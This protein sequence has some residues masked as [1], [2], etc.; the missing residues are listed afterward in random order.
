M[1]ILI[2]HTR[3]QLHGG[4]DSVVE[5]ELKLLKQ[6]HEVEVMYFQNQSGLRGALQFFVSIWNFRVVKKIKKRIWEFQ[7]DVVHVHNWHFATGPLLFRTINRV[8]VPLVHTVH[9]Y[10]LLCPSGIL[11]NKGEL[12]VDSLRQCFPWNAVRK[13][14]YRSSILLTLWLAFVIW[15]HKKLGTWNMIDAYICL[16][17]FAVNLFQ[18]S[19]LGVSKKQ[20]FVKPNF[21]EFT[22][23]S[24]PTKRE[25][26]F[27]FIGRLSEEKGIRILLNSFKEIP[28][29]LRIAGDGPLR[30]EVELAAKQLPNISYL[31]NLTNFDVVK[32][33]MKTEAL[34]FPSVW[35]E[36][37]PMTILEAFSTST[38]VIASNLG[39]MTSLII[40]G[41]NGFHFETANVTDL[42]A[43]ISKFNFLSP[44]EKKQMQLNAFESYE[45]NYAPKLQVSYFE[46]IYSQILKK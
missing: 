1:K 40:D 6:Q 46:F 30:E 15:F 24:R 5:Q 45:S 39:A 12:F 21:T 36:G 18:Q 16:T 31:G 42:K 20:F 25:N 2:I 22:Q 11:L 3:Y 38:P 33:L 41:Y 26:H 44:F 13:K 8:G 9:N 37:M 17:P 35:Y 29:F 19:N 43:I 10:R 4:E 23:L 34:L 7:P 32:E 14:V 27:L 28:F